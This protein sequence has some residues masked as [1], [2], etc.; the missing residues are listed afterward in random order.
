SYPVLLKV[1]GGPEFDNNTSSETFVTPSAITEYGFLLVNVDSRSIPGLGKR[2][3]DA[4]YRKL[5]QVD[6]DDMTEGAKALSS[7]S[8]AARSCIGIFGR[9]SG[10]SPALMPWLRP[11]EALSAASLAPPLTDCRNSAPIYTERYMGTPQDNKDGY[12]AGSALTYAAGLK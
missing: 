10:G 8:S 11:P 9:S 5:G 4:V 12:D 2:S 1:Y 6:V 7:R 3:R